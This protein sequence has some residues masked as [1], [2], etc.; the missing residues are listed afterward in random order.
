M[1]LFSSK[2][3]SN[4]SLRSQSCSLQEVTF[5]STYKSPADTYWSKTKPIAENIQLQL[6]KTATIV[7]PKIPNGI[8]GGVA[9]A[10]NT[11]NLVESLSHARELIAKVGCTSC[12]FFGKD[13]SEV[14]VI[15][16]GEAE[17]R[18]TLL[19]AQAA[20]LEVR[21]RLDQITQSSNQ[22]SN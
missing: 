15:L 7:C 8:E 2:P 12:R 13:P 21:N 6:G 14:D 11:D 16:T 9:Y 5:N 4:P 20:E 19:K 1:G 17:A 3:T 10:K 18:T 22:G